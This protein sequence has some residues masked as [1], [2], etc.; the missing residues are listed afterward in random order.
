[1]L[2]PDVVNCHIYSKK[3]S[4]DL[5]GFKSLILVSNTEYIYTTDHCLSVVI[6][7]SISMYGTVK[8]SSEIFLYSFQNK[9]Q[10][11]KLFFNI[12]ITRQSTLVLMLT[13]LT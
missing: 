13:V 9:R 10:P 6:F 1:M 5:K 11:N 4:N 8:C 3:C 2:T 7:M 12:I